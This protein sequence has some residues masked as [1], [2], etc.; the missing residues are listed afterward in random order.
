MS[1]RVGEERYP[2][3]EIRYPPDI[4]R[5]TRRIEPLSRPP[6][7]ITRAPSKAE[8]GRR[9]ED[10][11]E[12]TAESGKRPPD[13]YPFSMNR[14]TYAYLALTVAAALFGMTFVFVKDVLD[15]I[16]PLAFVGRRF[17]IGAVVLLA[18]GRPVCRSV[19]RNGT[20]AGVILSSGWPHRR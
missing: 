20:I 17:L 8:S 2:L 14:R 4:G 12:G 1:R 15:V 7:A 9:T 13:S 5:Q 18:L 11:G 6:S 3:A 10:I 16:P 19:W